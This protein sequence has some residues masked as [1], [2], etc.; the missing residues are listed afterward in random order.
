MLESDHTELAQGQERECSLGLQRVVYI[1]AQGLQPLQLLP[2]CCDVIAH[3]DLLARPMCVV[4]SAA[5]ILMNF[6][7]FR[8]EDIVSVYFLTTGEIVCK[9]HIK[10]ALGR[11]VDILSTI[12][13][14]CRESPLWVFHH[15][16]IVVTLLIWMFVEH[17]L[18]FMNDCKVSIVKVALEIRLIGFE[19]L[20]GQGGPEVWLLFER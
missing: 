2:V 6:R 1:G 10:A 17:A 3:L 7:L 18:N 16:H 9:C 20:H 13:L 5:L 12:C 4:N 19:L 8:V 14:V 15:V 11:S